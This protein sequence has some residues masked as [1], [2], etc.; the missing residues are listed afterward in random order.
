MSDSSNIER[1]SVYQSR[2][3]EHNITQREIESNQAIISFLEDRNA[4]L[5]T[6]IDISASR[7]PRHAQASSIASL[8]RAVA[9][10]NDSQTGNWD[11]EWPLAYAKLLEKYQQ[12]QRQHASCEARLKA[13]HDKAVRTA[14][15]VKEWRDFLTKR[16]LLEFNDAAARPTLRERDSSEAPR[17]TSASPRDR[18]I[19]SPRASARAASD[20]DVTTGHVV[21]TS[22]ASPAHSAALPDGNEAF[23]EMPSDRAAP[24]VTSSQTTMEDIENETPVV[25]VKEEPHSDDEPIVVSTRN[26]KR[27]RDSFPESHQRRRIKDELQSPPRELFKVEELSSDPMQTPRP[28]IVR[29]KT[30]DLDTVGTPIQTP[31]RP[32]HSR[33]GSDGFNSEGLRHQSRQPPSGANSQDARCAISR[34]RTH[35]SDL[36]TPRDQSTRHGGAELVQRRALAPVS[37]NVPMAHVPRTPSIYKKNRIRRTGINDKIAM[38]SEDG[39]ESPGK[40][41]STEAKKTSARRLD[42]ILQEPTKRHGP[43]TPSNNKAPLRGTISHK[44]PEEV[45][46]PGVKGQGQSKATTKI[47]ATHALKSRAGDILFHG[48]KSPPHVR[49]EDEPLRI[50]PLATLRL[51]DFKVN[52]RYM[53]S[54]FAF[55]DTLRG[56]DQRRE[57][58]TC[59]KADCCG[60]TFCKVIELGGTAMSGKTDAQALELYLGPFWTDVIS[61]YGPD[62]RKH[63]VNQ[64]HVHVFAEQNGKHKHAFERR[65][66]PPGFWRTDMPT[67][68]ES[69][70]DRAQARRM[71]SD[72][73]EERWREALRPNGRWM[74]RDE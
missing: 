57:L 73:V 67:T 23:P 1:S 12:L 65:S 53:G 10:V 47:N 2:Q 64:A 56:R 59:T 63:L 36:H 19:R 35:T 32:R 9:P 51:E 21:E 18:E 69:S 39:E 33:D 74:F 71:E 15:R 29:M 70:Q 13:A 61:S 30:S 45:V 24:R 66:T 17:L 60:D 25:Q 34:L 40:R 8:H 68:Q 43:M 16:E 22:D 41:N 5:R 62:E 27:K 54:D 55:A 72:A 38:L 26:L 3:L 11:E 48:A 37:V 44:S 4:Q 52:P 28:P 50:R 20:R 42:A 31:R 7:S 58:H 46:I 6:R 49:P 14:K